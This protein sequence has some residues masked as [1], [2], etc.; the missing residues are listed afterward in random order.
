MKFI[1]IVLFIYRKYCSR[2][3]VFR[4]LRALGGYLY[5][6]FYH[7]L[8]LLTNNKGVKEYKLR[9]F[10]MLEADKETRV[11]ILHLAETLEILPPRCFHEG[12]QFFL[13]EVQKL[14]LDMPAMQV[15]ERD[16]VMAVSGTDFLFSDGYALHHDLFREGT[17]TCQAE[18][19]GVVSINHP[20]NILRTYFRNTAE[21]YES[22]LVLFGQNTRNYAHWLIET[23]PK[24]TV[25]NEATSFSSLPILVEDDLHPNIYESLKQV[26]IRHLNII[27]I[28]R[29]TPVL[30]K[31]AVFVSNPGYEPY[32]P[33]TLN[34]KIDLYYQNSYSFFAL[35]LLRQH[36]WSL[37]NEKSESFAKRI[38]LR[39]N[40]ASSN[41]RFLTNADEIEDL[42]AKNGFLIVDPMN[43]SFMEQ[44]ALCQY[45]E[46][47]V[48]PAGAALA[49]I[50]FSRPGARVLVLAASR[51]EQANY[52]IFSNLAGV[53]GHELYY[54]PGEVDSKRKHPLHRNF[55]ISPREL[56]MAIK[57]ITL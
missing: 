44:V 57:A 26:N 45:A 19:Y 32:F 49:N 47:I 13:H 1:Q 43:M 33:E 31:K 36:F 29:W 9:S 18:T 12:K 7:G 17:D 40:H 11:T 30:L 23:L 2:F 35:D 6:Q 53:L 15:Y 8:V 5:K 41:T 56:G 48:A 10:G 52:F 38:Y 27:K 20:K 50:I 16:S 24:L 37:I 54:V 22:G 51:N 34:N 55:Y 42:L 21:A 28:R 25:F 39:R 46:I 4:V 3:R 14:T